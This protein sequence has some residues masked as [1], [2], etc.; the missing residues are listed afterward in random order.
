L[1][2]NA[3]SL[4]WEQA[5]RETPPPHKETPVRHIP[6]SALIA[7]PFAGLVWACT[8]LSSEVQGTTCTQLGTLH[9]GD[10]LRDSITAGSCRQADRTY[11]NHYLIHL[12][13]QTS[14]VV[15]LSSPL[16]QAFLFASD[17]S[18]VVIANSS[19]TSNPDTATTLYLILRAGSYRV[20]V[21]SVTTAPSGPLRLVVGNDTSAIQGCLPVWVTGGITTTQTLTASDCT[22]GP[23]GSTYYSHTYLTVVLGGAELKLTEHATVFTPQVLV[24][25]QTKA[26]LSTSTVDNTGTN[27]LVDY[28]PAGDAALL[29]WVG[30][31]DPRGFGQYTLT[32]N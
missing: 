26:I 23:L 31:T 21:N 19:I 18:G 6:A 5:A 24:T 29:L 7:I 11:V 30:G 9:V 20:S 4:A 27:A 32:I 3:N 10:T 22:T 1:Q 15:S 14:L 13:G 8:S 17:S 16:H 28:F 2:L 25:D 12:T